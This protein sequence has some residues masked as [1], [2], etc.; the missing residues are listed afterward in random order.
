MVWTEVICWVRLS[1]SL[2]GRRLLLGRESGG[3]GGGG[4]GRGRERE[5]TDRDRQRQTD[6]ERERERDRQT[7]RQTV[8]RERV[9]AT[10]ASG[11]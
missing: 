10:P 9:F 2:Y 3:G 8:Y 4:G 11:E 7:D 1:A 5:E 6:R